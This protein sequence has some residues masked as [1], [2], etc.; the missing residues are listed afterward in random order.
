MQ[1]TGLFAL[2]V[3]LMVI[4]I[5]TVAV[6]QDPS[7]QPDGN[8]INPELSDLTAETVAKVVST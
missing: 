4:G 1:V 7:R 3:L 5:A 6:S 8:R 2:L